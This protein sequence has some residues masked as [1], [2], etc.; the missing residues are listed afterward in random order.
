MLVW[1]DGRTNVRNAAAGELRPRD[2]GAV[3][4]GR[5]QLHRTGRLRR[6]ARVHRLE[7]AQLPRTGGATDPSAY[8]EFVY[9]ADQHDTTAKTFT[10]PDL[11]GR[12][13]HDSRRDRRPTA[14]R[15][16]S[17]SSRRWRGIRTRRGGWR[18]S[19]GISSSARSERRT[20]RSSTSVAAEYLRNGLEMKPVVRHI[21]QSRRGSATRSSWFARYSWPVEFVV[22]R[23]SREVGWAGF[24]V[25]T[26]RNA[27]R[28]TWGSSCSS[29]RTSTGGSSGRD[30]SRPARC[31]RG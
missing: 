28:R 23:R 10:L 15:T 12:Q 13:P 19:S 22:A 25:D 7:P 11:P 27:A 9:N 17:T 16:G 24:S 21:L 6:R 30:G 20:R 29:R 3:H 18:A 14:C 26:A 4:D 5:R 1:L 31:S 8:Y 2:H